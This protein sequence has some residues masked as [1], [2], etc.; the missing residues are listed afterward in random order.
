[1]FN[2]ACAT[3]N[4]FY[5]TRHPV[6]I[7]T[8]TTAPSCANTRG[9]L[10]FSLIE[11]MVAM[12]VGLLVL[13]GVIQVVFNS[14]RSYVDNQETAFIQDNTRYALDIIAKDFRSAGY[15]GCANNDPSIV[16]VITN[17]AGV[18]D[19]FNVQA[20]TA[21][22]GAV[23]A[24]LV[25]YVPPAGQN[26]P[27]SLTLR[28][29]SNENEIQV[30]TH[31]P[32]A[33][34][35]TTWQNLR[36]TPGTPLMAIDASC[37]SVAF[38]VASQVMQN[39]INY[40]G[41]ANCTSALTSDASFNCAMGAPTSVRPLGAGSR[42]LPYVANTYFI[43][44]STLLDNMPA[45]KR[46]FITV[47]PAGQM[48]YSTEEIAQGVENMQIFY[49]V[50]TDNDQLVNGL[51]VDANAVTA[52]GTWNQVIAMNI[53]LTLRSNNAIGNTGQPDGYLR[54]QVASTI[55]LRNQG[56]QL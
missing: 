8:K 43:G 45:L 1:M 6:M 26:A 49:G 24:N 40:A 31:N 10:G 41:A 22:D 51:F 30:Q 7:W 13:A 4:P 39:Q 52:A 11:L 17:A 34:S 3:K 5:S 47:N 27:D 48:V 50:D 12:L 19:A 36:F 9:N 33:A 42:I 37:Q 55:S 29:V 38:L 32:R 16:N 56:T 2:W 28:T 18:A 35:I 46:R 25:N 20:L 15:R 21:L 54:K 14:K 23:P 44:P 53:R